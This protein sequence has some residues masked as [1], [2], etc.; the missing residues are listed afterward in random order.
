MSNPKKPIDV[1]YQLIFENLPRGLLYVQLLY[2]NNDSP[3][4]LLCLAAN[5]ALETLL[6]VK[7]VTGKKISEWLPSLLE[8]RNFIDGVSRVA[9]SGI[10]ERLEITPGIKNLHLCVVIFIPV[11]GFCLIAFEKSTESKDLERLYRSLFA[12]MNE[13][14]CLH[15]IVTDANGIARDYRIVDA[16]PAFEKIIGMKRD[17]VAGKL[18][19]EAY[20]VSDPPYL[21]QYAAVAKSGV[22]MEFET[23]FAPMRKTFRI[24]VYAPK[25]GMFATIFEDITARKQA[26]L[27]LRQSQTRFRS[28][29]ENT[30]AGYFFIDKEGFFKD[31]NPAWV[32]LYKYDSMDEVI[33][34]NFTDVQKV[35]DVEAA[36]A[37]VDG[38][39]HGDPRYCNGEFSRRCKD[40]SVGYHY[41]CARPVAEAGEVVGIEGFIVDSTAKRTAEE[42]LKAQQERTG[43]ILAGIVDTFYSL[44]SEWRFTVV[45]PAAEK[46]PFDRR[47]SELLGR[48]IWEL[49]PNLVGT[50]IHRRYLDA[51]EHRS[52]EQYEAQS[53]LNGRWY[54]VF[55]QG[56]AGGVDVY[57]RDSTDRKNAE[58]VL[59]NTAKL[60]ALGILAGGIAHDFNNLL[61]GIYGYIDIAAETAADPTL[62][63]YLSKAMETIDRGRDLTR[64]LLTFSKGGDPI[65]AAGPLFP[66]VRDT[67]QFALSGSNV[68]CSFDAPPGLWESS[69][70]KNQIGQA[71][72]NIVINAKQAMPDGGTVEITARNVALES[73]QHP[74]LAAGN[75]VK[76]SIA[77]HGIGM[78]KEII[79]RI[80]D[81]FFSTKAAGHGLGLAT[82]FSIVKR[83]GGAIDVDSIPG[84]GST[85]SLYLPASAKPGAVAEEEEAG[86]FVGSGTFLIMDDEEVIRE[87]VFAML[88]SLGYTV[89]SVENGREALD[90]IKSETT[91]G[92]T[93]AGAIFDLTV[94]GGMGGREAVGEL[95][96]T[97]LTIPVFAASGHAEDPVIADPGRFGFT[98]SIRKPFVKRDLVRMLRKHLQP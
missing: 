36:K 3:A 26:D 92:R 46:A 82:C 81:P 17:E 90:F 12:T 86:P 29:V 91:A 2:A 32:R 65:R 54:E 98:A 71:I 78:P 10:P 15:E 85:F 55:M 38:I 64:Q 42:R 95:R 49:Y 52:L 24:V 28:I 9:K 31:V 75:Y 4:D 74:L 8:N 6:G 76:L 39:M 51:A 73:G 40:G 35:E 14:F 79:P 93:L 69:F 5:K 45:N 87:V 27:E 80:F 20:G 33:G 50:A 72:D 94:P 23:Y 67:V 58:L 77:D 89:T 11:E 1:P 13:G 63:R 68:S 62:A 53:P 88:T 30:D 97:G 18:A 16:N 25:R 48:V 96:T 60:E 84:K 22:P 59:Q 41:F 56:W 37:F 44:D 57:M 21:D 47:A 7:G 43:A 70:D 34:R 66:F 61:G 83:H 19:T